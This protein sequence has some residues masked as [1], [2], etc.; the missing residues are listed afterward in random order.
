MQSG[1]QSGRMAGLSGRQAG[2]R[3][4]GQ[5]GWEEGR[6]EGRKAGGQ[7][8]RR[9]RMQADR[10][11]FRKTYVQINIQSCRNKDLQI[12]TDKLTD[13]Q[14]RSEG[15]QTDKHT[16]VQKAEQSNILCILRYIQTYRQADRQTDWKT[17]QPS[18]ERQTNW[19]T[20]KQAVYVWCARRFRSKY[21]EVPLRVLNGQIRSIFFLPYKCSYSSHDNT[22]YVLEQST[23]ARN[24]AGLGLLY[25]SARA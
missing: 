19:Q 1:R 9:T 22:Y 21:E 6:R 5:K 10:Q 24:R 4:G 3:E 12:Y 18:T 14:C 23:G 15:R 25:L 16:D 7:E 8:C 13:R 2:S 17:E 20:D 11:M